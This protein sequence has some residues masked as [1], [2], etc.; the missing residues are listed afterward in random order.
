MSTELKIKDPVEVAEGIMLKLPQV[1]CPLTHYF[2]PGVYC[3]EIFMPAGSMVIGHKHKTEHMNIVL[4]G[5][6]NVSINGI[7]QE[8]KAPFSF[9]SGVGDRKVLMILEDMR[10]M[11]VHPTDETDLDKLMDLLIEKSETFVLHA[12]QLKQ[13]K[14]GSS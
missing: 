12:E 2:T 3:R 1:D 4:S 5:L 9:K 7:V 10:W 13:L 6:A 11:T 14:G 8:I